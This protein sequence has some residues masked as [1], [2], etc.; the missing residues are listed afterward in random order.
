MHRVATLA[1]PSP[2]EDA[3]AEA[4]AL[5]A[6]ARLASEL[7][8]AAAAGRLAQVESLA[9][10]MREAAQRLDGSPEAYDTLSGIVG[11]LRTTGE[12]MRR[13]RRGVP[14]FA[15]GEYA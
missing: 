9:K 4:Q 3:L 12:D 15:R 13:Q 10:E 5:K 7:Q 1:K 2:L 11:T 14:R 8:D 6:L